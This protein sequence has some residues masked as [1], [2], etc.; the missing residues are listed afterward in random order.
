MKHIASIVASN[1]IPSLFHELF[2][3]LWDR[4]GCR[5]L[6]LLLLVSALSLPGAAAPQ[7]SGRIEGTVKN[8]RG[9]PVAQ[10][11]VSVAGPTNR[12]EM[13]DEEG[14]YVV[15]GLAAGVYALTVV[16]PGFVS[17]KQ[18]DVQVKPD[19]SVDVSFTLANAPSETVVVTASRIDAD[20]QSAPA[21]V[22][23]VRAETIA[24][25]AASN[26]GDLLRTVPGLNV[27]QTSAREVNLA[28]RQAS[29][30]LTNSQI[31]LIDGRTI[32]SDF[33]D[34][35]FWD[36]IPVNT[37]DIKQIEVV[38][39]PVSAVWGAN[40]AT[41][42][43]NIITKSPREAPGLTLTLTGGGF[44]RDAGS[45]A[46]AGA[47]GFGG[48]SATFAQTINKRWSYRVSTGYSYSDAYPRPSGQVP[49]SRSPVD[50]SVVVGGGSYDSVAYLNSGTKQPKFDLR[51]DQEIG[52]SGQVSYEGGIAGSQ[53]IIQTTIGPFKMQLGS[54]LGYGRVGYE[55]GR[56]HLSVFANLLNGE[57]PNLL[58]RAA[59][60]N[61][62]RIH[63]KTGTYDISGGYTQLVSSRHLLNYGMNFRYNTFDISL[64]PNAKDRSEIGGYFEDEIIFGKL[65]LPLGFRLD[66]FSSVS[67]PIFSPRAAI[68]F[69]PVD[70]HAFRFSF[71]RAHRSPS[72]IDNYL[73]ISIIGGYLPL[74][75]IN[76]AFGNQQFPVVTR[77]YGNSKLKTESLTGWEIGYTG[78]LSS[79]TNVGL[80][81]YLNDSNH[82]INNLMSPA[83]LIAAGVQPFYTSQNPPPGWPLPP[84]ILDL[85]A[86]QGVFIPANVQTLNYGKVRN[87]GFEASIDQSLGS[88]LNAFAN[89][90]FQAIPETRSPLDDPFVYPAGSLPV[91]PRDRFNVGVNL[92]AKR[93]LGSLSVNYAGKAFWTDTSN[94]TF[95][96]FTNSYTTVNCSF[97][98]RWSEGKVMTS[99]KAINLLN[100]N[101][102]QH[103][104]GD[105]LKRRIFGEIQFGF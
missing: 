94:M 68:V 22:S 7:G 70:R 43:V 85:L 44:S 25:A 72:A 84:Q 1:Q 97:G 11:I 35:I 64:A 37:S 5:S 87:K 103:I 73:D 38:R 18:T 50:P 28:S 31:A 34:V 24:A 74:A 13:S 79:H 105:I 92:N 96:G 67:Q 33:Y 8:A 46:G 45:T 89:Y 65:R 26:I 4:Q 3:G 55:N 51:I 66:R 40:A 61:V 58:T 57:A 17:N 16:R 102:Q 78:A 59:D 77:S 91:P 98:V 76:P 56:V 29:P 52:T 88:A 86:Q 101:V 69:K 83:A 75:M 62:L 49:I 47:G 41:G 36:L 6:T 99:L 60:G 27:V 48:A 10:A 9:G 19:A 90:S 2:S 71:N 23:V 32:Y 63:F 93:Y 81:I 12:S 15:S 39:G 80:A 20:L 104:F 82:V 54:Y 100:D 53:G 14:R 30:T 95:Y 21:A 42:A